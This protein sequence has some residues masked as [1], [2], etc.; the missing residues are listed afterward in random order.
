MSENRPKRRT[1]GADSVKT[2]RTQNAVKT[3]SVSTLVHFYTCMD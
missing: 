1:R 3:E 2:R